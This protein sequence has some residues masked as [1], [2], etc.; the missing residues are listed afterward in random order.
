[1]SKCDLYN[2]CDQFGGNSTWLVQRF[3]RGRQVCEL[4]GGMTSLAGLAVSV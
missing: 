4:G 2:V 3:S 1:M